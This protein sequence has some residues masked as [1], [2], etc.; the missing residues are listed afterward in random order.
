MFPIIF[1]VGLLKSKHGDAA[2]IDMYIQGV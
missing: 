2:R 1:F